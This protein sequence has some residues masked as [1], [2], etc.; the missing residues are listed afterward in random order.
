MED[1]AVPGESMTSPVVVTVQAA[2]ALLLPFIHLFFLSLHA[3]DFLFLL[4]CRAEEF[5]LQV[6]SVIR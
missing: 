3:A 5:R 6:E 1:T 2:V 4:D